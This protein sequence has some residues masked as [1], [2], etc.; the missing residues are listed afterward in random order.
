MSKLVSVNV[1]ERPARFV[2]V[3]RPWNRKLR[4]IRRM[5]SPQKPFEILR[6]APQRNGVDPSAPALPSPINSPPRAPVCPSWPSTGLIL[7][8][9]MLFPRLRFAIYNYE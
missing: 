3:H 1:T 2:H 9:T 8:W 7:T 6:D 5:M 4:R